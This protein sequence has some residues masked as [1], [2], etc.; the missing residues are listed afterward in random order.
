[1]TMGVFGFSSL[2]L[3]VRV[4]A[5]SNSDGLGCV[6]SLDGYASSATSGQ[7]NT[8]I[9]LNNCSLY[10][11]SA[12]TTAL[13]MGGS[14]HLTALSVGVVGN[15][16]GASNITTTNGIRTGIGAVS[17]P[18]ADVSYPAFFDCTQQNFSAK[19]TITIDPG[20]YCGG[21]SFNA[22]ANVTFNPGI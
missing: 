14:A 18:Y 5:L 22:G 15:L 19:T 13:V 1:M 2:S 6:M 3:K 11:N 12:S 21:M 4:T 9:T 8:A 17:D 16:T 7:G 10:D 20:V